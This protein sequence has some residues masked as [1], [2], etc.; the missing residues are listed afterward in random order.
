MLRQVIEGQKREL[1]LTFKQNYVVRR[2]NSPSLDNQLIKVV[3][4]SSRA[5]KSFYS[6][7]LAS[8]SGAFGYINFDD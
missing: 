1:A 4:G 5:G 8:A 6:Q 7:H 3:I 2:V